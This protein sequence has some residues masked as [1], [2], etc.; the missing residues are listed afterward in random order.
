MTDRELGMD[1]AISR[2]DF[3]NGMALSVGAAV[4]PPSVHASPQ[5]SKPPDSY[6]PARTGLRGSHAGSFETAHAL[7]DGRFRPDARDATDTGETYDLVVVGGGLSG[8]AAAWLYRERAG[9]D[10]RILILE[11]HDDI[12]G[13]A[14]RNEFELNGR[15]L[16]MNGGTLGIDSPTPYSTEADGLLRALGIEPK[17]LDQRTTNRALYRSLGLE[18]AFFFDRDTFGAD[19]LIVGVGSTPWPDLLKDSPLSPSARAD[20]V[21]LETG[22]TD[23]LP[24]LSSA[25]KKA[26]LA[27][28]SYRDFLLQLV[29]VDPL[30]VACYQTRT[31]GEWG[32]GIDAESALDC[33]AHGLP[34][35]DGMRLEPGAAPRM[36]YTAAG[37][38]NGGSY[39]YHFP[40]GNASVARLL[41]RSLVPEAVPGTTVDDVVMA[42]VEYERCD[43]PES[44]VRVRLGATVVRARHAGD[45]ATAKDVEIAYVREG[46]L[47]L[48][49]ARAC[50]L[51]CWAGMVPHLCPE[52]PDR[53]KSALH[54]L[55]KV[56]LVYTSV[57]LRSWKAFT[58][59]RVQS[60][61]SPGCFHSSFNLTPVVDIGRYVSPKSADEPTVIRMTRTPCRPGLPARDQHK[62]GRAELMAMTFETFE[63]ATR[64]QLVRTL[65]S[66][67]FDPA[68]DIA[69]ITV[70]RWPHGYSYEYNPLF[71]PEW[72][73]G[74]APHE[75]GRRRFG[76]I[77]I[78]NSDTAATAYTD[79]AFDQ[80]HR[81]VAELAAI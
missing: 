18:P 25:E 20:L 1:V 4:A 40:D 53:Q 36:S 14:K 47:L 54:Y 7:R 2:R 15:V 8:L 73:P 52:L 39:R 12:G 80:A 34:G 49:R 41:L 31:H 11:N 29:K 16:L 76:R 6:P 45:P 66:G 9:R 71:D 37:Y 5:P 68:R 57:A 55:V 70:N 64:D 10:A 30:V 63:R 58:T 62:A 51:A 17:A 61:T 67:G 81:A 19:T 78:A 65:S 28:L 44:R 35:F 77:A 27:T 50:V 23:Y 32:V 43:R 69:A 60:V 33:W 48:V 59:L 72:A 38:A 13:H 75:I 26:K 21:R 3:L 22:T 42:R 46:R 74:E 79:T 24:G 56:P